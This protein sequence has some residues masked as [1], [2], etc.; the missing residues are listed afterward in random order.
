MIFKQ[1]RPGHALLFSTIKARMSVLLLYP[2]ALQVA[3]HLEFKLLKRSWRGIIAEE[4]RPGEAVREAAQKDGETFN[5]SNGPA[6]HGT[7][8]SGKEGSGAN[9]WASPA[10]PSSSGSSASSSKGKKE[11]LI[12]ERLGYN[13]FSKFTQINDAPQLWREAAEALAAYASEVCPKSILRSLDMTLRPC[14]KVQA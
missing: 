5:Q 4:V 12:L 10:N 7:K 2:I 13:R 6:S 9:A 8:G 14:L 1:F 11:A 3:S